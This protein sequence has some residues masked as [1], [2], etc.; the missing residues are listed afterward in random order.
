MIGGLRKNHGPLTP[1]VLTYEKTINPTF[2]GALRRNP[3]Y[4]DALVTDQDMLE[5]VRTTKKSNAPIVYTGP[6]VN[7]FGMSHDEFLGAISTSIR[8]NQKITGLSSNIVGYGEN[9]GKQVHRE[10]DKKLFRDHQDILT[11]FCINPTNKKSGTGPTARL[12]DRILYLLYD[13]DYSMGIRKVATD[14]RVLTAI[15]EHINI[16]YTT[17]IDYKKDAKMEYKMENLLRD[18]MIVLN[19]TIRELQKDATAEMRIKLRERLDVLHTIEREFKDHK[20]QYRAIKLRNQKPEASNVARGYVEK[21]ASKV[22]TLP[23]KDDTYV[24]TNVIQSADVH[25]PRPGY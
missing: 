15:Q 23:I 14:E 13:N 3:I 4:A 20:V 22:E 2:Q 21:D 24:D 16:L 8:R 10:V 9:L 1:E 7:Q 18:K 12:C 17:M 25:I 5:H 6:R 19:D 11:T